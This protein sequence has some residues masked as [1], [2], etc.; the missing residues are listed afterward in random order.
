MLLNI[1]F[2]A[3]GLFGLYLGGTMFVG[4][5]AA[6]AR[7]LGMSPLMVG[8]TVVSIGTSLPELI[9]SLGAALS[10]RSEIA[11]GN[12]IGSN[13]ANIGL[14]LGLSGLI[15]PLTVHVSLLRRELPIMVG[16]TLLTLGLALNGDISRFDGVLLLTGMVVFLAW[17]V[18]GAQRSKTKP[19]TPLD[20]PDEPQWRTLLRLVGG[21]GLLLIAA[22]LTVEGATGAARAFGVSELVIGITLVAVGTSLPELVTSITAALQRQ[23]DIAVGNIV[24][25]NIFNLL[26]IL[27]ATSLASPIPVAPQVL[28]IDG[29]VMLGFAVLLLPF[30][31]NRKLGKLESLTFLGLYVGY[32]IYL[33]VGR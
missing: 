9:V 7:R 23:S 5:S 10:G 2:I 28:Q 14:I 24:G 32:N 15:M 1:F 6:L 20:L 33:F 17:T 11:L 13:I 19:D 25:S 8:L 26:G 16:V 31:L 30:L 12:V 18:Y 4:A 22:Q 29:L 21:L 3:L 27:G